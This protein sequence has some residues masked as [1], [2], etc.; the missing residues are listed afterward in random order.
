M[1]GQGLERPVVGLKLH[2]AIFC[3]YV[4]FIVF[5][6]LNTQI[7]NRVC[8]FSK[9]ML[10][11]MSS[12]S[13]E[14]KASLTAVRG[15]W[16][17]C[18]AFSWVASLLVLVSTVYMFEVYDRVVN[19]RSGMTLL[20]L[21]AFVLLV[22]AVMEL[23][24]WSR[25]ETLRAM[26]KMWDA[27]ITPRLLD[28]AKRA[29][30]QRHDA[31]AAQPLSDFRTLRDGLMNPVVGACMEAPMALV[32]LF[33]LFSFH[34]LLGWAALVGALVQLGITAWNEKSSSPALREAG[35]ASAAAHASLD[36]A[37]RHT[38]VVSAMGL[39]QALRQ[40]WGYWQA[41]LLTQQSVAS[42]GAGVLQAASKFIQTLMGSMLL[43]LSAYLLLQDELPGGGGLM[44]VASVLGGRLLAPL[45]MAVTQWRAVVQMR[46]SWQR[47]ASNLAEFPPLPPQMALPV[48]RGHVTADG[49]WALA[50]GGAAPLLKG[51]Q[52]SLQPGQCLAVLGPSGAGKTTL[53]RVLV[54]FWPASQ[55]KVRLDGA[56][57]FAW[58]KNELGP[59]L[60]YLPQSVDLL[61]GTLSE[62]V[63]RFTEPDPQA[64]SRALVATGLDV[65]ANEWPQGTETHLGREGVRLS[66]GQRQRVGLA[67]AIYGEPSFVV[68]DEPSA[69]LD[70]A[71]E[72]ML[73]ELITAL[74]ARG[75]C[76][77]LMTHRNALLANVDQLLILRDGVPQAYGPRD[78]VVRALQKAA[79]AAAQ[80][81]AR[82]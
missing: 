2:C 24:E 32:I 4:L 28:V 37:L 54:G 13:C 20:M 9:G 74:K 35:R 5:M 82:A 25:N 41:R 69:H 52:L 33:V 71:G 12:V 42:D 40:R 67:R 77:V 62:N 68:L 15:Y 39:Q 75:A 36:E 45:V 46:E 31:Q 43:G 81:G 61:D 27:S 26:G 22:Y 76:V 7:K 51:V 53:A 19:S 48:P 47:L 60:G 79:I 49:V 63:A 73:I 55:G 17:R 10:M 57:L 11:A 64:L 78:D 38:D 6:A 66:A 70:Q 65:L 18:I 21:T 30:L 59:F 8:V 34:P 50:P 29:K 44:I 16:G 58:D 14:L 80:N 56:D 23:V 3:Q 72:L 1:Q